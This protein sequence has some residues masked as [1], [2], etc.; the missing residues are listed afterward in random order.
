MFEEAKMVIG[1][2]RGLDSES[3]GEVARHTEGVIVIGHYVG[4]GV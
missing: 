2:Y 3:L 4:K 1:P